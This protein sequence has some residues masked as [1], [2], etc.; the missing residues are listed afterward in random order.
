MNEEIL[1]LM[2][3]LPFLHSYSLLSI[4]SVDVEEALAWNQTSGFKTWGFVDD[5]L[6]P[7]FLIWIEVYQMQKAL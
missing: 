2:G 4:A 6:V 3:T 1:V 7:S 5:P